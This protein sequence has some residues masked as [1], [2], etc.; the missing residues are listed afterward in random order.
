MEA[1]FYPST[2]F[3][4]LNVIKLDEIKRAVIYIGDNFKEC[5]VPIGPYTL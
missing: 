2:H 1:T 3:F 4:E 5:D